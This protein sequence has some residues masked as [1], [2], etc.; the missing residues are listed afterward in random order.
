MLIAKQEIQRIRTCR[1]TTAWQHTKRIEEPL[2]SIMRTMIIY[3]LS[4]V[5][6]HHILSENRTPYQKSKN[7]KIEKPPENCEL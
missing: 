3:F 5:S 2:K 7:P 4:A 1:T 6:K